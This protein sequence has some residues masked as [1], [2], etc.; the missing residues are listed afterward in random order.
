MLHFHTWQAEGRYLEVWRG[1]RWCGCPWGGR[2]QHRGP[3]CRGGAALAAHHGA[4]RWRRPACIRAQSST[5]SWSCQVGCSEAVTTRGLL[6]PLP[7]AQ[8]PKDCCFA[9]RHIPQ[10]RRLPRYSPSGSCGQAAGG[11]AAPFG[12]PCAGILRGRLGRYISG[13]RGTVPRGVGTAAGRAKRGMKHELFRRKPSAL[14]RL[15]NPAYKALAIHQRTS[16]YGHRR[17]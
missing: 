13:C 17:H 9:A 12:T 5:L 14:L 6:L 16:W 8:W 1:P 7:P 15:D 4:R 10:R 2:P 3:H 11:A